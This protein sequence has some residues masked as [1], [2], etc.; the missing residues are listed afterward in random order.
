LPPMTLVASEA[1]ALDWLAR[2]GVAAL[3]F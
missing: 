2:L 1:E 3:P